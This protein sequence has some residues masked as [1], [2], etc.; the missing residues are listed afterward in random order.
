[1]ILGCP[2]VISQP[3]VKALIK[4][5]HEDVKDALR[6]L[7]HFI[8]SRVTKD[9]KHLSK[10]LPGGDSTVIHVV[11]ADSELLSLDSNMKPPAKEGEYGFGKFRKYEDSICRFTVSKTSEHDEKAAPLHFGQVEDPR[12]SSW[13]T[14]PSVKNNTLHVAVTLKASPTGRMALNISPVLP[15][16][17]EQIEQVPADLMSLLT[18]YGASCDGGA[19]DERVSRFK[20]AA[21]RAKRASEAYCTR[22]E[23]NFRLCTQGCASSK[24]GGSTSMCGPECQLLASDWRM[25]P[26][27]NRGTK[28]GI[29]RRYVAS[30]L[31]AEL[32]SMYD[33]E[34]AGKSSKKRAPTLLVSVLSLDTM[35]DYERTAIEHSGIYSRF[36]LSGPGESAALILRAIEA[37]EHHDEAVRLAHDRQ[38]ERAAAEH[39]MELRRIRQI[40]QGVSDIEGPDGA[41]PGYDEVDPARHDGSGAKSKG[42]SLT[43]AGQDR[44]EEEFGA[45]SAGSQRQSTNPEQSGL[46]MTVEPDSENLTVPAERPAR[47]RSSSMQRVLKGLTSCFPTSRG[48]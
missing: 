35:Q 34:G 21:E 47:R 45:Q 40:T 26:R 19:S 14:R 43:R 39:E 11:P 32:E 33:T 9:L 42:D 38:Q 41:P 12:Q 1:V 44:E 48:G 15:W 23:S 16:T 22:I 28:A 30:A 31:Q 46:G 17:A 18:T 10:S 7:G 20:L 24:A 29:L 4:Q 25:D 13:D 36:M 2:V 27:G 37:S 3:L 5:E 6:L 8:E